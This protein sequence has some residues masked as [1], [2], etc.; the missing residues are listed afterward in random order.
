MTELIQIINTILSHRGK[1]TIQ[2]LSRETSLRYDIGFD[3]LDLAE[4]TVRVEA[5]Y[6][7]DVFENGL[8]DSIEEVLVQ[9]K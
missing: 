2:S 1:P 8:V 5:R 3:S 6:G 4:F 7:V 9:L